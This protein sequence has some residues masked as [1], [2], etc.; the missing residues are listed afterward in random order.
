MSQNKRTLI[1]SIALCCLMTGSL[2]SVTGAEQIQTA[3]RAAPIQNGKGVKETNRTPSN[4]SSSNQSPQERASPEGTSPTTTLE[5]Y[6]YENSPNLPTTTPLNLSEQRFNEY[7]APEK[8]SETLT[9][10]EER[11]LNTTPPSDFYRNW[12][13]QKDTPLEQIHPGNDNPTFFRRQTDQERWDKQQRE[14]E[15]EERA[16]DDERRRQEE[17]RRQDNL[18]PRHPE[19]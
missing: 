10:G 12:K 17:W 6:P 2:T 3:P 9:P 19:N 8:S 13:T 4:Q 7:I 15:V 14:R 1:S 16:R 5:S 18:H 11:Y